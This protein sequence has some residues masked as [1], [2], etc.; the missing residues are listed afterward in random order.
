M[1]CQRSVACPHMVICYPGHTQESSIS[2]RGET[3]HEVCNNFSP[4]G[5][6]GMTP[7]KMESVDINLNLIIN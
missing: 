3:L 4:S 6:S 2:G 5:V 7:A 1:K